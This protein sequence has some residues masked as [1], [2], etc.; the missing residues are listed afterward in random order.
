MRLDKPI[1][2]LLL[3]W[4]TLWALW[5]AGAGR[6]SPD[7]VLVF[8]LGV[9]VMRS[10]GCVINDFFDAPLDRHVARTRMRPLAH[11]DLSRREAL[12]IFATLLLLAFLLA[13]WLNPL[14]LALAFPGAL[15]AATYPLAKRVTYLPQ[16]Y[17]GV[18]FGWGIPMAFAA[19]S[20]ALPW[21]TWALL[22]ANIFW[23]LAYDTLYAMTDREDD[24]RMGARSSA[25]LFG[26]YDRLWIALFQIATLGL[27]ALVGFRLA[28]G[29]PYLAGLV[30]AAG[31]AVHHQRL[32]RTR[33]PEQ[34]FRAF[35]GNNWFGALVFLG[36]WASYLWP[37]G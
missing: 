12:G 20:N 7:L 37:A 36:L 13:L 3:L 9:V 27:L 19:Q 34:C 26:R 8:V 2:T 35:L 18:A 23:A 10:A 15:L 31:V 33:A 4:P 28:L 1:G 21:E 22:S 16:A 17:L 6:P 30:G 24:A 29:A 5:I 32:I 25:L 11:G 14:A